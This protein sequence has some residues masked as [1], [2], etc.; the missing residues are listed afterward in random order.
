VGGSGGFFGNSGLRPEDLARYVRESE[1]K[2]EDQQFET[3]VSQVMG[4]LLTQ[5]NARDVDSTSKHLEVIR[6]TLDK[7]IE[8]TVDLLF[9]GSVA[10]HT[11]VDGMSDVDS[12]VLLNNTELK[13]MSP[14]EVKDYF[15]DQLRK[16]FPKT[17]IKKGTLA[18]TIKFQ[19]QEIQLLPALHHGANLK[20]ANS[21]GTGWTT[22]NPSNFT[23]ILTN[24]NKNL[25]CKLVP[26]IKLAKSII[27]SLPENRQLTGYHV[28]ALA[29]KVFE[30]YDGSM[31]NKSMLKHFFLEAPKYVVNPIAELTGQSTHV[32]AYLGPAGDLQ[33]RIVADSIG[34]LGRRMQN[35]DGARSVQQWKEILG[36]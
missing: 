10:K 4:E 20:I 2:T 35:A 16:R 7:D 34:R 28:E 19:D 6:N 30:G 5:Y 21:Q 12:L 26:T 9:G 3:Q 23:N 22:I 17:D 33:R 36:E 31:T 13:K 15:Y 32:D 11:Y 14:Q 1:G 8:G 25:G 18:V 27:R 24:M 29:L